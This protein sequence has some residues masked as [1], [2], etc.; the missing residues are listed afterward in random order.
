MGH[1][2]SIVMKKSVVVRNEESRV[3]LWLWILEVA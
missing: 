3:S 1:I 2:A